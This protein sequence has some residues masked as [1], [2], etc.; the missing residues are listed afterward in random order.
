MANGDAG[1]LGARNYV[2]NKILSIYRDISLN[3]YTFQG[4]FAAGKI[5]RRMRDFATTHAIEL[6][7][8]HFYMGPKSLTHARRDTKVRDGAVVSIDAIAEFPQKR[9]NM[10]LYWDGSSFIYTDYKNKFILNPNYKVK[11]KGGKVKRVNFVTATRVTD[12]KE[13]KLPKYKKV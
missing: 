10:D 1:D 9:R 11:Q 7:S 8:Q 4:D 6:A 2:R 3:K 12:S 5:E 13:F